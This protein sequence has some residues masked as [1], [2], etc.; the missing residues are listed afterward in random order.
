MV[1][2]KYEPG[3]LE[4][5]I[6][7]CNARTGCANY[8]LEKPSDTCVLYADCHNTTDCPDCASGPKNCA[9]GYHGKVTILTIL[10]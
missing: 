6:R 7:F 4:D 2:S 9:L 3:D 5:C 10:E 8:T 1:D